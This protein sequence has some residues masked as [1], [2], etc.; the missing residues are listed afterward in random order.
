MRYSLSVLIVAILAF[1]L[2]LSSVG[3][4]KADTQST[5]A[6]AKPQL[7]RARHLLNR[8]TYGVRP[9]EIEAVAQMGLGN[10]IEKQLHGE[11]LAMPSSLEKL[12]ASKPALTLTPT[13]LFKQYGKPAL[14]TLAR[15]NPTTDDSKK[16]FQ[17]IMRETYKAMYHDV[18]E[19]RLQRALWSPKQLEE[20]MSEFWFNHFNITWDKGMDHILIGSYEET[21]IRPHALGKFRDL[22]GATT[23]HAAML[24]YLDNWQNSA[25]GD[26]QSTRRNK[27]FKGLNENYARE[28]MEL[29]TLGVD[30][31]Y[32]QQDVIAL[33]RIL[34]GLGLQPLRAEPITN[35]NLDNKF[36]SFFDPRRHDYSDKVLLGHKIK[37]QGAEEIEQAL[38]ILATHSSTAHHISYKLAQFFVSDKPPESLVK[39]L[40]QRF[41]SAG[42]DIRLVLRELFYS[43]EFWSPQYTS[44]KFKSPYRYLLSCLRASNSTVTNPMPL[45]AFLKQQGMP[46]YQCLTPDGYKNTQEAWLDSNALLNRLSFATAIGIGRMPGIQTDTMNYTNI[47]STLDTDLS[48]TTTSA[49]SAAPVE[50]RASLLLGSPEFMMY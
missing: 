36:G 45:I 41:L 47:A 44:T 40:S 20:L 11:T 1:Q 39:R 42:G 8:L 9:G 7:E 26:Y 24:F 15:K 13:Q 37:G 5:H 33:A 21:A 14:M 12:A 19:V 3:L 50:L 38:D 27:R 16:D 17:R 2:L 6:T 49:V 18:A 23:H 43:T 35:N 22:L 4:A 28:L 30:G 25:P 10:F 46:L 31:P 32:T 34:T 48:S 29:H